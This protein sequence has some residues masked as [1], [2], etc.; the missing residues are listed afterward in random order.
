MGGGAAVS[1]LPAVESAPHRGSP[2]EA[3]GGRGGGGGGGGGPGGTGDAL[4]F[5]MDSLESTTPYWR[6]NGRQRPPGSSSERQHYRATE[7]RKNSIDCLSV[8]DRSVHTYVFLRVEA[9]RCA[10]WPVEEDG[11]ADEVEE[12]EMGARG[13]HGH[14]LYAPTLRFC[15]SKGKDPLTSVYKMT[16][17]LQMSTSGPS[18][19]FPWKSSGAA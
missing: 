6:S 4:G 14:R 7:G 13:T 12:E 18:Y 2:G 10:L 19:F 17:R 1:D 3:G 9:L 15:P 5:S 11:V 16:P 8:L